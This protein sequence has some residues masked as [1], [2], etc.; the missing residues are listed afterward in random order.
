[1]SLHDFIFSNHW[2]YRVSRH[3]C[4]WLGWFL[5]S[6]TVQ[7]T[8]FGGGMPTDLWDMIY[9]QFLRSLNRLPG[10]LLFCYFVV[11]FLV[12]RFTRK[13]KLRQFIIVFSLAALLLYLVTFVWFR[14]ARID[15]AV[16]DWPQYAFFYLPFYSNINFTGALST[17]CVMLAIKYY[18]DWYEKQ[19]R[20]QQLSRE[21]V[22]A[23]L[24]LLKAQVHPHFLFNTLNNIYSFVLN[25]DNRAAGLVDKLAG[26]IDYMRTEGENSLVPL[27]KEIRLIK[28]YV[29]LE[30]VRYG[31]RL[32]LHVDINAD[33]DQKF[34]APLLMIPFVENSF[35]HGTSQMLRRPWI[36]LE[37][38]CVGN[39]LFFN[40]SNSKPSLVVPGRINKGIGLNNVK[41]R[42]QLLYP[43]RHQLDIY[44]TD[45]SFSVNMQVLLEDKLTVTENKLVSPGK[46]TA[47]A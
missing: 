38:T 45:E 43:G 37:I 21:N 40:L 24:Q 10:I 26:M 12:P 1:M 7:V 34:I 31:D 19:H 29:E 36:R 6:G 20:T 2:R 28:D 47:Y 17:C 8:I 30:K 3:L 27:E 11:Y 39:Q 9:S 5:F 46:T 23:E 13:G 35:K 15:P 44:S 41:K 14:Y 33:D 16:E 4:F 42:L 18:K 25:R 32:N 22:Q